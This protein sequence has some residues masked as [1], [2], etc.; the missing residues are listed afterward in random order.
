VASTSAPIATSNS[1]PGPTPSGTTTVTYNGATSVTETETV[2]RKRAATKGIAGWPPRARK[3]Q[4][5]NSKPMQW[6]HHLHLRCVCSLRRHSLVNDWRVPFKLLKA[7]ASEKWRGCLQA[8]RVMK[9][10]RVCET[11]AQR[12]RWPPPRPPPSSRSPA[13]VQIKSFCFEC[14]ECFYACPTEPFRL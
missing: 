9:C 10:A 11:W 5:E 4:T 8:H 6:R 12:G 14:F 7:N 2:S 3:F 13:A 1:S